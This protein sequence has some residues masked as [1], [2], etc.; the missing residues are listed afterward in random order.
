[1][2]QS[3][4]ITVKLEDIA[5]NK[6]HD[7][8]WKMIFRPTVFGAFLRNLCSC[9]L[10]VLGCFFLGSF[11]LVQFFLT[12]RNLVIHVGFTLEGLPVHV[13]VISSLWALFRGH[14][15]RK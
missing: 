5:P 9:L 14:L 12:D 13:E 2:N 7:F 1:M 3:R 8:G 11:I 6:K 10:L 4:R 15:N